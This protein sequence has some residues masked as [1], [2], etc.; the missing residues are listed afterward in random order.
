MLSYTSSP[1]QCPG[2]AHSEV[3]RRSQKKMRGR[4]WEGIFSPIM[5]LWSCQ[6]TMVAKP[7]FAPSCSMIFIT[8]AHLRGK[9]VVIQIWVSDGLIEAPSMWSMLK[10]TFV[11]SQLIGSWWYRNRS[12]AKLIDVPTP[13]RIIMSG[14]G[15][16]DS[17][18]RIHGHWRRTEYRWAWIIRRMLHLWHDCSPHMH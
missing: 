16:P 4:S 1:C 13:Y 2:Y 12:K 5:V 7:R 17:S 8:H 9:F 11:E 15:I 18:S 14:F 6:E 3:M 10:D